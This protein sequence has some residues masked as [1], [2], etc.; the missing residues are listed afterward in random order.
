MS[1]GSKE[2]GGKWKRGGGSGYDQ[3]SGYGASTIE[4]RGRE[5]RRKME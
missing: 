2:R 3:V 5:I 1:G 4:K